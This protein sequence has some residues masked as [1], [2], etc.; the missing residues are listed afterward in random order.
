MLQAL[1]PSS[2]HGPREG[3][4]EAPKQ[5]CL[6]ARGTTRSWRRRGE[7][8]QRPPPACRADAS[9]RAALGTPHG[10]FL[11]I[12]FFD[13]SLLRLQETRLQCSARHRQLRGAVTHLSPRCR[14]LLGSQHSCSPLF[15]PAPLQAGLGGTKT[16]TLCLRALVAARGWRAPLLQSEPLATATAASVHFCS[17]CGGLCILSCRNPSNT[18]GRG[19]GERTNRSRGVLAVSAAWFGLVS[20]AWPLPLPRVLPLG[21]PPLFAHS[22]PGHAAAAAASPPTSLAAPFAAARA[23]THVWLPPAAPAPDPAPLPSAAPAPARAQPGTAGLPASTPQPCLVLRGGQ[24]LRA[25][26]LL[27]LAWRSVLCR[28][29]VLCFSSQ[30]PPG[31]AG[32]SEL[33]RCLPAT[34]TPPGPGRAGLGAAAAPVFPWKFPDLW[35]LLPAAPSLAPADPGQRSRA[36]SSQSRA[37]S[38]EPRRGRGHAA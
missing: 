12:F 26:L 37:R 24:Q 7:Q 27:L 11:C 8:A 35:H 22:F 33:S 6:A 19:G 28:T 32:C 15:S 34:R 14:G 10:F 17:H 25:L 21:D 38:T 4:V 1:L 5:R 30:H 23:S 16:F 9:P 31:A 18:A 2:P 36:L 13:F 20:A 3:G 29:L